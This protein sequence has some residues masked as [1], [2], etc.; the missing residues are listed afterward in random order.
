MSSE[1]QPSM[2]HVEVGA[3]YF[4]LGREERRAML[5]RLLNGMSPNAEVRA[6]AASP[7]VPNESDSQKMGSESDET[8]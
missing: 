6:I 8:D 3:G 4:S 2:Q 1:N 7:T 5:R